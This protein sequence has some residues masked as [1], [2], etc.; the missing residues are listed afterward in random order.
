MGKQI[1][2]RCEMGTFLHIGGLWLHLGWRGGGGGAE[3]TYT[4]IDPLIYKFPNPEV[5]PLNLLATQW[6]R[7]TASAPRWE[8]TSKYAQFLA[9]KQ[10]PP[11]PRPSKT[12]SVKTTKR[13]KTN[14]I[15]RKCLILM[16]SLFV[17]V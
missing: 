15:C 16:F 13:R 10:P 8:V 14:A 11:P 17:A 2:I 1:G 7:S 4:K 3:L 6:W 9:P 12:G 5:E